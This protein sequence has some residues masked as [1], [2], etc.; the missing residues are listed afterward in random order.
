MTDIKYADAVIKSATVKHITNFRVKFRISG[1]ATNVAKMM[2][3]PIIDKLQLVAE[4]ARTSTAYV[5]LKLSVVLV[6]GKE[7]IAAGVVFSGVVPSVVIFCISIAIVPA[8]GNVFNLA[9]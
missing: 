2:T 3:P 6:H 1:S 5:L 9:T 7:V 8:N 4:N